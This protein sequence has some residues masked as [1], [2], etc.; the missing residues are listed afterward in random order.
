MGFNSLESDGA[1]R[2]RELLNPIIPEAA[3]L[4]GRWDILTFKTPL[5]NTN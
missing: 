5:P 3:M 4:N 1:A 2:G